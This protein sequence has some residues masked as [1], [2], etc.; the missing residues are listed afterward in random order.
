MF[1]FKAKP[2]KN[3]RKVKTIYEYDDGSKIIQT[4]C[5]VGY[6]VWLRNKFISF[7]TNLDSANSL[8]EK[9]R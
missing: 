3:S 6:Q 9:L 4:A 2:V 7:Q 5:S 1:T 8:L